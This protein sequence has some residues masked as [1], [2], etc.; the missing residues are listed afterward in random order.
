M[1]ARPTITS[2]TGTSEPDYSFEAWIR[3]PAF[4][5]EM[6]GGTQI[7]VNWLQP[8]VEVF[9]DERRRQGLPDLPPPQF[10]GFAG[11]KARRAAKAAK[12]ASDSAQ[13]Q[14][15]KELGRLRALS[16]EYMDA[17][18]EARRRLDALGPS[19]D[20]EAEAGLERMLADARRYGNEV[21]DAIGTL[22]DRKFRR[23]A[24][25]SISATMSCC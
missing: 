25:F 17:E 9:K 8:A 6:P 13:H 12:E 23:A 22:E 16:Y 11:I 14:E 5:G 3:D 21:D 10:K 19:G 15:D 20:P 24:G 1:R 18:Q 7:G 4:A 2:L